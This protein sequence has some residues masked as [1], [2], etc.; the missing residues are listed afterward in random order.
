MKLFLVANEVVDEAKKCKKELI[1]FKVDFE[2]A[3]DSID[4]KYLEEVMMKMGFPT[5]WRKWIKE[6][7][8]VSDFF[9]GYKVGRRDNMVVSHPQFVDDTLILGEKLWANIPSLRVV[10]LL[11]EELSGLKVIF[12]KSMLVGVN[13]TGS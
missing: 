13:V 5:L 1:L 8:G 4:W 2:K 9:T 7:D 11:S 3:Y 10:L 12:S 6:C